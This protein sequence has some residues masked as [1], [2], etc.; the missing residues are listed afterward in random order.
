MMSMISSLTFG[1]H[2][3]LH[4]PDSIKTSFPGFLKLITK[5]KK[6]KIR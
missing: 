1:G 3:K 6:I 2:W 5:L 4:D